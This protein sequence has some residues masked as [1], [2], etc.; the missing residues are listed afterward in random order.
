MNRKGLDMLRPM[1]DIFMKQMFED[2][3]RFTEQVLRLIMDVPTLEVKSV[4]TQKAPEMRAIGARSVVLDVYATDSDG[5]I[6][7]IEVQRSD[8]GALPQRARY[9]VGAIDVAEL[10]P[11]QDFRQLPQTFVI[12]ITEHDVPGVDGGVYCFD[13]MDR[14]TGR[15][16]ED[17]SHIIY[18]NGEYRGSDNIGDLV[19]DFLCLDPNEMRLPFMA[20]KA[21]FLKSTPE[22][23]IR[24]NKALDEYMKE[25][26][27]EYAKEQTRHS[28]V[29]MIKMGKFSYED[30][31]AGLG[32]SPDE[33]ASLA[34]A[35]L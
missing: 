23:E 30:I 27:K 13:R 21:G 18:V 20:E 16:L 32:I 26:A 31:A 35:T 19:H 29:K 14:K 6:Y 3:A 17:G 33:V 28:A 22:G 34:K 1:D 9:H 8:E 2:D 12:F 24:M 15:A 11:G 5:V 10:R 7:N 25:Y 4:S